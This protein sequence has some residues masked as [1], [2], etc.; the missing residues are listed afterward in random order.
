MLVLASVL[1]W[2]FQDRGLPSWA[3]VQ[4]E[5]ERQAAA[6]D[7]RPPVAALGAD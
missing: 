1:V 6:S 5:V 7:D 3:A 4:R 2:T